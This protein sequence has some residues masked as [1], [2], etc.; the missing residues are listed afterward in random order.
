LRI[1][2]IFVGSK[3][4]L[5]TSGWSYKEWVGPFYDE[6]TGMLRSYTS[7]FRTAEIDSTFYAYPSK[8]LVIGWKTHT[9]ADFIFTA[10]L[11]KIITHEKKLDLSKGVDSDLARFV[12]AMAPLAI[13]GKLGCLLIQLPPSYGFDLDGLEE[14]FKVLPK[15]LRFAVEFRNLTWMRDET[16]PLLNRYRVAYVNVDEPLLPPDI[17]LTA[18]FTYFR[19]HGRGKKVWFDYRYRKEELEPWVPKVAETEGKVERVY[20][21]FNNH[22]HGYAVENCL[23]VMEMLG[24]IDDNQCRAK[25]RVEDF[26][27]RKTDDEGAKTGNGEKAERQGSLDRYL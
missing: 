14:F 4:L 18:D 27:S 15:N 9:P 16:W 12:D 17:H 8:G 5:G 2:A 26:L 24:A 13:S 10:K 6:E 7:V 25:T 22:Y 3:I 1:E 21:F 11:P 19:W 23:Q 20:G